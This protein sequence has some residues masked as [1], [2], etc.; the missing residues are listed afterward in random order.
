MDRIDREIIEMLADDARISATELAARLP[1][2]VSATAERLRRLIGS[3]VIRRFTVDLDPTL[4]GRPIRVF[5]DMR[6][7]RDID[8]HEADRALQTLPAVVDAC[9]V[10]GRYDYQLQIAAMDVDDLDRTLGLLIDVIG[11]EET[12]TRLVL[13]AAPGFPRAV[14]IA[15]PANP[16]SDAR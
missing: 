9:H 2:S 15:E 1:L 8:K 14:S 5:V 12:N 3:G 16:S 10:T 6:L 11:A 4:V 7:R 13:A